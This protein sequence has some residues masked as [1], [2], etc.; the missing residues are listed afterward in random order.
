MARDCTNEEK[1]G[2]LT[3]GRDIVFT[4]NHSLLKVFRMNAG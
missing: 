3:L 1:K 4:S 2:G